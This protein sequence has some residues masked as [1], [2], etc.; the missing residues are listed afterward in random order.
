M[1]QVALCQ[2]KGDGQVRPAGENK[3]GGPVGL[4]SNQSLHF[5][6]GSVVKEDLGVVKVRLVPAILIL[7]FD[8]QNFSNFSR[9]LFSG[10]NRNHK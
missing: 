3:G 4:G 9:T 8:C 7:L 2:V 6:A 5:L 10:K 1:R